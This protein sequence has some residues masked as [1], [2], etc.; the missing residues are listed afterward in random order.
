[1][2][3]EKLVRL[4]NKGIPTCNLKEFS[5][6]TQKLLTKV[7]KEFQDSA[8]IEIEVEDDY[9]GEHNVT[10]DISYLR[11][12]TLADQIKEQAE[13]QERDSASIDKELKQLARL[14]KKYE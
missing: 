13:Q 3:A 6:W 9:D 10:L 14:K 1:M 7:P 4:Y 2:V 5:D 12:Y 11:P 8:S